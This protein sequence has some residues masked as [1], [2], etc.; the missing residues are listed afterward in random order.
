MWA[1]LRLTLSCICQHQPLLGLIYQSCTCIHLST[2]WMTR[3]LFCWPFLE[4]GLKFRFLVGL[5]LMTNFPILLTDSLSFRAVLL[6]NFFNHLSDKATLQRRNCSGQQAGVEMKTTPAILLSG[7]RGMFPIVWM[8]DQDTSYR[9][10]CLLL[11]WTS[12]LALTAVS[13]NFAPW[14][15]RYVFRLFG[16]VT[17]GAQACRVRSLLRTWWSI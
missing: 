16:R 1:R 14:R 11:Q 15:A 7:A 2:T 10:G 4:L 5:G 17:K 6:K 13:S 3:L 9:Y 8:G 12:R